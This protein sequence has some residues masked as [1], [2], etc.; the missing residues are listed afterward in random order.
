VW[1]FLDR[2]RSCWVCDDV[3]KVGNVFTC[4]DCVLAVSLLAGPSDET[5]AGVG[6]ATKEHADPAPIGGAR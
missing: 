5:V 1:R 3:V 2:G 4:D 6:G